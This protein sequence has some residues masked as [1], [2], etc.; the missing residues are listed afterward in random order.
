MKSY[1]LMTPLRGILLF[2]VIT[3]LNSA[4]TKTSLIGEDIFVS[5]TLGLKSTDTI[6]MFTT[7]VVGEE[8]RVYT[9]VSSQQLPNYLVGQ[10]ADPMFGNSTAI[11]YAQLRLLTTSP[12]FEFTTLDSVVLSLPYD[13][14]GR[15]YGNTDGPQ[16]ITI[17]R[18]TESMD[19]AE[20]IRSTQRFE[21]G[22]ILGQKTFIPKFTDSVDILVPSGDTVLQERVR[23]QLRIP[24]SSAFGEE[25]LNSADQMTGIDDF[26]AYFKGIEIKGDG[27]TDAMLS[28]ALSAASMTLYYTQE[29]SIFDEDDNFL[30]IKDIPKR[31]VFAVNS[32]SAKSVYYFNDRTGIGRDRVDAP[33]TRYMNNTTDSL[34]FVQSTQGTMAKVTFPYLDDLAGVI[35]NKAELIVTVANRDNL[36]NFGLPEQLILTSL[37]DS[38]YIVI[39]D[40][41]VSL[42]TAGSFVL[43]GGEA[44]TETANN[45]SV[46]TYTMNVTG[47]FQSM[48][49]GLVGNDLFIVTFPKPQI[50]NR[51]ILGG[52]GHS[53]YPIKLTLNYTRLE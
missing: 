24:L 1:Q 21:S 13:V 49:D 17:A 27:N 33:I 40:M 23:P 43:F 14:N 11:A 29:D 53:T 50:A 31:Y 34:L 6:S 7:T 48:I 47:H 52:A 20:E 5:D 8:T 32:F 9:P 19:A 44:V 10:L 18:L 51:V 35:V 25:L 45:E 16:T 42:N 39:E 15:H 3:L 30:S 41:S 4:C 2:T 37:S 26:L 28:L 12:N 38:N 22:Q 46:T 36:T